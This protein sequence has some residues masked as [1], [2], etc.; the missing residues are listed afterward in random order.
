M[1]LSVEQI[2]KTYVRDGKEFFALREVS[3]SLD[4]GEL[5]GIVGPSGSGKSTLLHCIAGLLTPDSGSVW[6]TGKKISHLGDQ[7][8]S[9]MRN[10][11]IG[12]IPQSV[13]ILPSLSVLDNVRL[14]ACLHSRGQDSTQRARELLA[15]FSVEHLANSSPRS[16]SGG[17]LRRVSIA[18]ALVNRP[19][20]LLADEPTCDLDEANT[21]TV[22]QA[23]R[24]AA[25]GGTAVL[26]ATHDPALIQWLPK[27]YQMDRGE[28]SPLRQQKSAGLLGEGPTQYK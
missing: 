20:L 9:Q 14:P 18:R 16:L 10:C 21:Q 22:L 4:R 13:G 5:V 1:L 12:Y 19:S 8:V 25:Q 2:S 6:L 27:L 17:E 23:L 26:L 15:A 3:L 24:R 28:L 7:E 11:E